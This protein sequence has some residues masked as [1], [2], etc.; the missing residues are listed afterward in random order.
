VKLDVGPGDS[1]LLV[2]RRGNRERRATVVVEDLPTTRAEP[3]STLGDM[4]LI[5]L[6]PAI[7]QERGLQREQG[8][9]IYSIG[10]AASRSTGLRSGDLIVQIDRRRITRAEQ[11]TEAFRDF[12]G[13]RSP[14]RVYVERNGSIYYT[15]FRIR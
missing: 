1:V 9:L 10:D 11:V 3:V 4:Q 6:T 5:T 8:V 12:S 13:S 2:Y 15:D 14:I 7:Q